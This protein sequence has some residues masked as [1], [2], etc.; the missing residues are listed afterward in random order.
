MTHQENKAPTS[1]LGE[2]RREGAESQRK[3]SHF[4]EHLRSRAKASTDPEW[5]R[6]RV[7]EE[8]MGHMVWRVGADGEESL[9]YEPGEGS[10][11]RHWVWTWVVDDW[12]PEEAD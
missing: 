7:G 3:L 11:D 1:S 2:L 4:R 5:A 10:D 9:T 8:D 12:L 6:M